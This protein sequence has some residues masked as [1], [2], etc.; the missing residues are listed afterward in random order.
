[1]TSSQR[2]AVVIASA[3]LLTGCTTVS[4]APGAASVRI[5]NS[6]KDVSSCTAVGNVHV[7]EY[8]RRNNVLLA[9]PTDELRNETVGLGGNTLFVT[10]AVL[11]EGVAYRCP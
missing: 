4:L 10:S 9:N 7:P 6:A 11:G 5:A 3:L 8:G 2:A 1:M